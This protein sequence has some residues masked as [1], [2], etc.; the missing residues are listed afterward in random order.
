MVTGVIHEDALQYIEHITIFLVIVSN[1]KLIVVHG[2]SKYVSTPDQGQHEWNW[3]WH[4]IWKLLTFNLKDKSYSSFHDIC[5]YCFR[6]TGFF[7]FLVC[8]TDVI[9]IVFLFFPFL[10]IAFVLLLIGK[11]LI[12]S[13]TI[14]SMVGN[15]SPLRICESMPE[16]FLRFYRNKICFIAKK[17]VVRKNSETNMKTI[18]IDKPQQ[19]SRLFDWEL[20]CILF[21]KSF[22]QWWEHRMFMTL[23]S[24]VLALFIPML[25]NLSHSHVPFLNKRMQESQEAISN[26][27]IR[28]ILSAIVYIWPSTEKK[29]P[30]LL[31]KSAPINNYRLH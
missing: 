11:P 29:S 18:W 2:D 21:N 20:F 27:T 8:I 1:A 3:T 9:D 6:Q 5:E 25:T 31:N 22:S 28:G 13:W 15:K 24:I 7:K 16:L 10:L 23:K 14:Y 4:N 19:F 17:N 12:L 26:L 30:L